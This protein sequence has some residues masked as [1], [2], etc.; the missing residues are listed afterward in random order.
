MKIF[1]DELRLKVSSPADF[2]MLKEVP[3]AEGRH[4]RMNNIKTVNLKE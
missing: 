4:K 3:Q 1:L 2:H